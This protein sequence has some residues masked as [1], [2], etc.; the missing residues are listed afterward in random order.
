[1]T[2]S[3]EIR[4]LFAFDTEFDADGTVVRPGAWTPAKRSYLPAEVDAALRGSSMA[5]EGRGLHSRLVELLARLRGTAPHVRLTCA[6]S[7]GRR[8][9][10]ARYATDDHA[11]TLFHRWSDSRMGRAVVSEPLETDEADWLEVPPGSFCVFEGDAVHV[12]MPFGDLVLPEDDSPLLL[13]SAGIGC[14]PVIGL[15]T[16]LAPDPGVLAARSRRDQALYQ[17][18]PTLDVLQALDLLPTDPGTRRRRRTLEP[19]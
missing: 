4:R 14:T 19:W 2:Q 3:P 11:P 6:F 18:S 7:D 13:A 8:L 5:L 9:Y 16:A 17:L 12:S 1:M 15:L 10:A